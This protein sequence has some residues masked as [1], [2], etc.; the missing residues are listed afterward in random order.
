MT[1][2][3]IGI[4]TSARADFGLLRRLMTAVEA[5]PALDLTVYATGMHFSAEHGNTIDEVRA[6]GFAHVVDVPVPYSGADPAD[7]ARK[8]GLGVAA[9]ADMFKDRRPDILVV[10]GDRFDA[11]PAAL[12]AMPFAIPIAHIAG[13]EVTVGV[14]DDVIRHSFTKLAHLHFVTTEVYA[15][16][17]RQLGEEAWRVVMAGQPGL[18]DIAE[19]S[20]RPKAVVWRGLDLDQSWPVS[21]LTYHPETLDAAGTGDAI[22]E[23]LGAAEAVETQI[24]FTAPNADTGSVPVRSAI[25]DFCTARPS[26]VFRASL[27]RALYLEV[28]AHAD[29]MVGNSSSGLIEAASFRLPVVNIGSRQQGRIAPRNVLHAEGR[30]G[31]IAE[32]WAQALDPAFR[33]ELVDLKNPYGD[34]RAT[35]RIVERLK[36]VALGP[37]LLT[38][39]FADRPVFP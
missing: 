20:A 23:V 9:F 16:R 18:D 17:V 2:R 11:Y 26:A 7:I 38:K 21:L 8:M 31:P 39:Q 3:R 28:L 32:A 27:G 15:Q 35:L 1:A 37:R 25:E 10:L 29:C 14:I 30:R 36:T 33:A 13:G 5:D 6:A 22:A 24:L 4:V 19:F 34:G 12:A